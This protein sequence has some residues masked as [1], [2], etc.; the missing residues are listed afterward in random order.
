MIQRCYNGVG[1]EA[2]LLG[3]GRVF[4]EFNLLGNWAITKEG[5]ECVPVDLRARPDIVRQFWSRG[6]IT[7][8]VEAEMRALG[9]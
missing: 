7:V 6:G 9:V 8:E 2:G 1:G 4:S 3:L 5:A